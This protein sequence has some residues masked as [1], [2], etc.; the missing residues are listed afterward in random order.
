MKIT[1]YKSWR[2]TKVTETVFGNITFEKDEYNNVRV[3]FS[4]GGH[5]WS[6]DAENVIKIED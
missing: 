2:K 5:E 3:R 1:Y 4:S 6:I